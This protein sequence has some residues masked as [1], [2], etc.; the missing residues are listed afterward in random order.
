[1]KT[2]DSAP[3][4]ASTPSSW[5]RDRSIATRIGVTVALMGLGLGLVSGVALVGQERVKDIDDRVTA[6]VGVQMD[7]ADAKYQLLWATN[8]QNITAWKSRVDG[9]AVAAAPDGDN[10]KT[11]RAAVVEFEKVFDIDQSLLTDEGR[12]SLA[13]IAESWPEMAEYNEDILGLWADEELDA[14]DA[15]STGEKWDIYFVLSG[16]MDELV[17]SVDARVDKLVTER[18]SISSSTRTTTLVV[19]LLAVLLGIA[20]AVVTARGIMTGIR[21]VR[22]GLQRMA[23]NDFGV[24]VPATSRDETGQM[25][26]A[27]NEAAETVGGA[28]A[29]IGA[30]ADAVAAASTE[31]KTTAAQIATSAE[32]ASAR[33]GAVSAAA[34][35][36]SGNVATVAA[37][38]EQMGV[39]IREIAKN[40]NDAARVATEAVAAAAAATSMVSRLGSSSAEIGDVV[41]VITS[42][43]AQTNLLALNATIEAARAGEAGK[44]FAVV[45]SEV[46]ELAQETARATEDISRRVTTIS[47]DTAG[48]V[49]AIAEIS[50]IIASIDDFQT[51]IAAAVEEQTATTNEMS[52]SVS[53]AAGGSTDI[54]LS[55]T[56]VSDATA[57]TT[58][59]LVNSRGA[60]VE[61]A[62]L[63]TDLRSQ[64]ARFT[65]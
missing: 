39:S 19:A 24:R 45:A 48:A 27:L 18:E 42:I 35:E 16:G 43:A 58:R 53:E 29:A 2:T 36:V 32:A 52:R 25:A 50:S 44:G 64:V 7:V 17:T 1:M 56:G 12:A 15:V 61:L 8:W 28:F 13:V 23:L 37:G 41:K 63:A 49:S 14:G 59:A 65:Y 11:Y 4:T 5:W 62:D 54:A 10:V 26:T 46:K 34:G 31:L 51:T 57:T 47:S 20:L 38:A 40:A 33:S 22:D 21:R 60:I 3:T 9:G 30:S 55:I 6:A